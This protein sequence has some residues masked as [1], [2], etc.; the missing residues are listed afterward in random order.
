MIKIG[1]FFFFFAFFGAFV[2][3]DSS[4]KIQYMD[5]VIYVHRT[6]GSRLK[7]FVERERVRF[8]CDMIYIIYSYCGLRFFV[9]NT[10]KLKNNRR[11]YSLKMLLF[12]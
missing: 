4:I 1:N 12:W 9:E 3:L 6:F 2:I 5:D 10:K 7:M 11:E 8:D